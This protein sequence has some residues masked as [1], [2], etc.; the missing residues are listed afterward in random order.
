MRFDHY[1]N[2]AAELAAELVNAAAV[3]DP[4]QR[5][6]AFAVVVRSIGSE[7]EVDDALAAELVELAAGLRPAFTADAAVAIDEVNAALSR[8]TVAPRVTSHGDRGPHLHFDPP[9]A[10]V[11]DR[12]GANTVLGLAAVVC[13]ERDRLGV[14]EA[15]G[16]DVVFVDTSRNARRRFCTDTCANRFHVA[17]HRARA[18]GAAS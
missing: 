18:K 9:G 15:G 11:A 5:A 3:A 7:V 1:A 4:A 6:E 13:D 17:A 12:L 10:S 2:L 8:L 14:C 16:C